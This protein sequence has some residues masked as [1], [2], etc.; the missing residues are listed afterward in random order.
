MELRS[1]MKVEFTNLLGTDDEIMNIA[2]V[3]TLK[4]TNI[5]YDMADEKL[6]G[7]LNFLMKHQ[8]GTPFEHNLLQ[9]RI[10]APIFVWREFHRHRI[11]FSYNEQSGRYMKLLPHFYIPSE[12]RRKHSK[13]TEQYKVSS[14]SFHNLGECSVD[15]WIVMMDYCK[16]IYNHT[17]EH[18]EKMLELGL[19]SGLAR[20]VLPVGL[21]SACY[22][23]CNVR[24]LIN[25]LHLRTEDQTTNHSHPL[26]EMHQVATQMEKHLA[27]NFP[28][29]YA[30][31]VYN[32]RNK[33]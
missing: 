27:E 8:H 9:F 20:M 33:L 11:G 7:F 31:W 28:V 23:T 4:D 16:S 15:E 13:K 12:E 21:Y 25:F 29:T 32:G 2:K 30:V 5:L 18:Y 14:P 10:E 19:D 26:F 1:D 6:R 24:S 17:Y 22:V 3:S